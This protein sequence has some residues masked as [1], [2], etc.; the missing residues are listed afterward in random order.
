MRAGP[1]TLKIAGAAGTLAVCGA[2]ALAVAVDTR[3]ASAPLKPPVAGGSA[4]GAP[5]A[6]AAAD[7]AGSLVIP[8]A[9]TCAAPSR[10]AGVGARATPPPVPSG[11]QTIVRQYTQA[12]T[13]QQRQQALSAL[14]PDQRMQVTAYVQQIAQSRQGRGRGENAGSALPCLNRRSQQEGSSA[15][16][17]NADVVAGEASAPISVSAVS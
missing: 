6:S 5:G 8:A 7:P 16:Q 9:G 1:A 3:P 17:I 4:P 10:A 14:T 12:R 2:S 13:Q 11:L 15:P